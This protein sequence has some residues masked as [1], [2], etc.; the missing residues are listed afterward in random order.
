MS[1]GDLGAR[2]ASLSIMAG[3]DKATFDRALP[4]LQA[5]GRNI[6]YQGPAGSGQHTKMANQIA[7]SAGMIGVCE[8]LAYA[9][10]PDWT[11]RRF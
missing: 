3:G 4:L 9:K 10:K 1:G 11:P 7:I 5:M 8:A 6:V 2:N